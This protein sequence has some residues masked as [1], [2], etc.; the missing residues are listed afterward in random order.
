MNYSP[1][2]VQEAEVLFNYDFRSSGNYGSGVINSHQVD[3][4]T[5]KILE[6]LKFEDSGATGRIGSFQND[7]SGITSH[8]VSGFSS[9]GANFGGNTHVVVGEGDGLTRGHGTFIFG[10]EKVDK[11]IDL[12]FSNYS[13]DSEDPKGFEFGINNA[14]KLFFEYMSQNGPQVF[15]FNI[16]PHKRNIYAVNVDLVNETVE[17]L[18]WDAS[19]NQFDRN[20]FGID[21]NFIR[22]S[23]DW[24]IGSGVYSGDEGINEQASPYSCSG[25][26]DHFIHF[27]GI[28][29]DFELGLI[30]RSF[31]EELDYTPA[32]TETIDG[33]LLGYEATITETVNGIVEWHNVFL[34]YTDGDTG[35]S[36]QLITATPIIDV[37]DSGEEIYTLVDELNIANTN[38]TNPAVYEVTIVEEATSGI[39]GFDSGTED[40][41][42]D[43]YNQQAIYGWSGEEGELYQKYTLTPVYGDDIER[44]ISEESYELA[45]GYPFYLSDTGLGYG[46]RSYTYLG[47]RD[48][49]EDYVEIQKGV[50]P[51]SVANF[52]NLEHLESQDGRV[53]VVYPS[54]LSFTEEAISLLVNGLMQE[55]C[56]LIIEQDDNYKS[57][58]ALDDSADYGVVD[59]DGYDRMYPVEIYHEDT[60]LSLMTSSPLIDIID[61]G[62]RQSL[63]IS[64]TGDYANAPFSEI[65]PTDKHVF[66]NGQKIY[67]GIDYENSGGQLNPIGDITGMTGRF[68]TVDDFH[69]YPN[70]NSGNVKSLGG[71]D[72]NESD[73]FVLDSYVSY[74]NGVRL[75]PKAHVYHDA[76]VDLIT[77]RP[78][79]MENRMAQVYNN[80]KNKYIND[81]L[82]GFSGQ[83]SF[84]DDYAIQGASS[85]DGK[86]FNKDEA[87]KYPFLD[88]S[89]VDPEEITNLG[90]DEV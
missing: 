46:P 41:G 18:W 29:P 9:K 67:E 3:D 40:A 77:A 59:F 5:Y 79:I 22:Q 75:D 89:E 69:Y 37:A 62:E 8:F 17:L 56:D 71:Y 60:G 6:L 64:D 85:P 76:E 10:H 32:V 83:A 86:I 4:Q 11:G 54:K 34:G 53:A 24:L 36:Y 68:F 13:G 47:A 81:N 7:Y 20:L 50:N 51:L 74:L 39:V 63:E 73:V 33:P 38:L 15:T 82:L 43:V 35:N 26:I 87:N 66:F 45:G 25:Y 2:I 49:G 52:A 80:Q 30:A 31:Y 90:F 48:S 58:Y 42:G 65:D 70:A 72:V 88:E 19:V 14:N 57:S 84:Y 61:S 21:A 44:T 16:I 55:R 78:F 23:D 12:I 28:V 1:S 27:N